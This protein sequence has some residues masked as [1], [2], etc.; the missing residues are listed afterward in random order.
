ML[1]CKL[2]MRVELEAC[3]AILWCAAAHGADS[4]GVLCMLIADGGLL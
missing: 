2:V 1:Y 3:F 4:E